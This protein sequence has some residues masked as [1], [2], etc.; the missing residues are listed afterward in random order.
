MTDPSPNTAADVRPTE[1]RPPST[2]R[3]VKVFGVIGI[4]LVLLFGIIKFAGSGN[5]GPD[6]HIPSGSASTNG[7]TLPASARENRLQ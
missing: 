6:R 2:P 7:E 4:V 3:W 1:D 5:H